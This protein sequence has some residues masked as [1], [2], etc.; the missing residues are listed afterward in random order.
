MTVKELK[1]LL[2]KEPDDMVVCINGEYRVERW[3]GSTWEFH[4]VAN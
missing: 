3:T 1:E 2:D 4:L